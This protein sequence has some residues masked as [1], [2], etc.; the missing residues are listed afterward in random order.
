LSF[1]SKIPFYK[2]REAAKVEAL[3]N[4]LAR[5]S[6]ALPGSVVA[7]TLIKSYVGEILKLKLQIAEIEKQIEK[8]YISL[9]ES[10][11]LSSI[12][13]VGKVL[14]PVIMCEIGG[15]Y[16][17]ANAGHLAAYSGVAPSKRQSG[18][19]LNNAKK[20]RKCNRVLKNA[21]CESAWISIQSD[22]RSAEFYNKKRAEG[23]SHAAAI[24]ALAR[25]RVDMIYA[26]LKTGSVYEPRAIAQ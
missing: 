20:K 22:S 1:A 26:I 8:R 19:S 17:F 14:G 7:E 3:F 10:K 11:A 23:K 4:V 13:G 18:T 2:T 6:L 21:F 12:P 9:N 15:I 5:Q 25:R 16:R 24:L